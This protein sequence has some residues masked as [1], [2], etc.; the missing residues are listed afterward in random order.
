[1]SLSYPL[2]G[3]PVGA[4]FDV[5]LEIVSAQGI[6]AGDYLDIKAA[7]QGHLSTS[8]AFT[9]IKVDGESMAWTRPA[10]ST[11][12][13]KWNEKFYFKNVPKDSHFKFALFDADM[14][15]EDELGEA[16]FSTLSVIYDVDTEFDLP[17]TQDDRNA[18]IMSIK[19]N[20]TQVYADDDAVVEEVGPVRY[21]V[22]S[23]YSAGVFKKLTSEDENI[24]SLAYI[25]QLHNIALY[26]PI[27]YHWN[28]HYQKIQRVFS[29]D[30]AEAPIL[31]QLVK[32]QHALVYEHNQK[33][34]KYGTIRA[35]GDFFHLLHNGMRDEKPVLFTYAITSNG[36][37]FSETGAGFF[38]DMLSKHMVHSN[39]AESV[40]Y[41]GEFRIEKTKNGT[42][43]LVIDNNSGTYAPHKESLPRL[44]Q[45]MENNFPGIVCEALNRN[46]ADLVKRRREILDAW[47]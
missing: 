12:N 31:R 15:G 22:H 16:H 43:K 10:F 6:K 29:P 40:K 33:S 3:T 46:D 24:K 28:K 19:V 42:R 4:S 13:P 30:H 18:G 14:I 35:P 20:F 1:M 47:D 44:K 41:A 5:N 39:A 17:I 38:K 8:D 11:L 32:T 21:S 2:H 23:S 37:F 34:T 25:V 36:W 26:M 27:D 7:F 45:L 9:V